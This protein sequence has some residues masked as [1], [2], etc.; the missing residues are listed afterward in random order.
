MPAAE[1]RGLV[2]AAEAAYTRRVVA[3]QAPAGTEPNDGTPMSARGVERSGKQEKSG[4]HK[5]RFVPPPVA[6]AHQ[7]LRAALGMARATFQH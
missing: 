1:V 3:K 4:S 6:I 7:T 2:E 5:K